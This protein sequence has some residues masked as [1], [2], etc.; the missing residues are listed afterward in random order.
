[1]KSRQ[2]RRSH[3]RRAKAPR[4][5]TLGGKL[6]EAQRLPRRRGFVGYRFPSQS[7]RRGVDLQR[8]LKWVSNLSLLIRLVGLVKDFV[9]RHH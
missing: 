1:M 9:T 6:L 5:R 7:R 2:P 4:N 8:G 3:G